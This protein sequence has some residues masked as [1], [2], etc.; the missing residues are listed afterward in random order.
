MEAW[1]TED[2]DAWLAMCHPDV[3][4]HTSGAFPDLDPVYRGHTGFTKFWQDMHGPWASLR[5]QPGTIEEH[6][7]WI[8]YE[9]RFQAKGV[10]S[11]VEVDLQ[12]ANAVRFEAGLAIEMVAHRTVDEARAAALEQRPSQS[13]S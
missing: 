1:N 8:V 4:F 2:L 10:E 5:L 6:G 13:R 11:G 9:L 12:M 7:D 3:E